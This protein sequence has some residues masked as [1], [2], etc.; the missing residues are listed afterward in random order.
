MSSSAHSSFY[1]NTGIDTRRVLTLDNFLEGLTTFEFI[2]QLSK[3]LSLKGAE[4]NNIEYLD[5]KPYIRTFEATLKELKKLSDDCAAK[6]Q[7]AET[8]SQFKNIEHAKNVLSLSSDAQ[9]LNLKFNKLDNQISKLSHKIAPLGEKLTKANKSKEHSTSIIVLLT[10]YNE[11]FQNGEP[12]ENLIGLQKSRNVEDNIQFAKTLKELILLA[13]KLEGSDLPN[14]TETLNLII[15]YAETFENDLLDQFIQYSNEYRLKEIA[16]ILFEFN[17][18]VNVIQF[19]V[20]KHS[21][22]ES[23]TGLS[24]NIC[25]DSF[26]NSI[27]NINSSDFSLDSSTI[28]LLKKISEVIESEFDSMKE[29]FEDNISKVVESFLTKCYVQLIDYRVEYM[30][31]TSS[32]FS[33]LTH[34][35]VLHLLY[36]EIGNLTNILKD[37]FQAKK[38]DDISPIIDQLYFDSFNDYIS[39]N[40]YFQIEQESLGEIIYSVLMK[41]EKSNERFYKSNNLSNRI[42]KFQAEK[43]ESSSG[44]L[45]Q[46]PSSTNTNGTEAKQNSSYA[47]YL[48]TNLDTYE[49]LRNIHKPGARLLFSR[50]SNHKNSAFSGLSNYIKS[51]VEKSGSLR[52]RFKYN[53]TNN[54]N[55]N[56][57]PDL[58]NPSIVPSSISGIDPNAPPPEVIDESIVSTSKAEQIIKH[59]LESLTRA[60][61]LV[62]TK[63]SEY[64]MDIYELLLFA[65]GNSYITVGLESIYTKNILDLQQ[66]RN[67]FNY[68]L[69]FDYLNHLT[70]ISGILYLFSMSIQKI[71]FPFVVSSNASKNKLIALTNGYLSNCEVGI[72]LILQDTVSLISKKTISILSAQGNDYF[73]QRELTQDTTETCEQIT[74][75]LIEVNSEVSKILSDSILEKFLSEV[76]DALLVNILNNLK[77]QRINSTGGLTLTQDTIHYINL[78]D[79]WEIPELSTRFSVLREVVNIFTVQPDL[80]PTL[81]KEGQLK[82]LKPQL[83]RLYISRRSD[84]HEKILNG[85]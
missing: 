67:L 52:D 28:E 62:P 10:S 32:S 17:D 80:I 12:S 57:T 38:L 30:L 55:N 61:E 54:G 6:K 65:L 82:N 34:V 5:P 63:A 42:K 76:G 39:H 53:I 13:N 2:E 7:K 73:Q 51:H 75:F 22:F 44:S 27:S 50:Y 18:G 1:S 14:S 60:V 23:V 72:D 83:I 24:E 49:D 15:K 3:D 79:N 84:F 40:K 85:I 66:S 68:D 19:F 31:K 71:M 45:L 47:N 20:N 77:R 33:N 4:F 36:S 9:Q 69:K 37:F 43:F 8:V 21:F 46:A 16:D 25:S 81:I 64:A 58:L 78:I 26:W 74:N 41:F 70:T 11:F 59:G 48:D 35:R 56:A 29:I